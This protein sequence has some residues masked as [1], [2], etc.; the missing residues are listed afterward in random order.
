MQIALLGP[1]RANTTA[2]VK[3]PNKEAERREDGG[4]VESLIKRSSILGV[5]MLP[6]SK[7]SIGSVPLCQCAS[8]RMRVLVRALPGFV[9][10]LSDIP[11]P[12]DEVL[13]EI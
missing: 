10:F 11:S 13:A 7:F 6:I 12:C 3:G 9:S 5:K 2:F 8:A 4:G 1:Q